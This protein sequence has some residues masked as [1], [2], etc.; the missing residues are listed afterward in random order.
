MYSHVSSP[1]GVCGPG[2]NAILGPTGSGK[3]SL[4]DILAAR[5]DPSGQTGDV[6]INGSPRPSNF[7]SMAGYVIQDDIVAGMLTVRENIAFSAAL[8]LPSSMP[9]KEKSARV[10]DV[11]N[12]LGLGKCAE[13]RVGTELIRGVSGGERKRTNIAMELI[14]SPQI[15]FL[16][17]PTT[18]LD[19]NTAYSVMHL[20]KRLSRRGKTVIFSVHQPRFSIY[21]LFDHVMLLS[22]GE[23]VYHGPAKEALGH[24]SDLGFV[25]E[26]HNNP[27]DFFLDVLNGGV[28][29]VSCP[30]KLHT[31]TVA[32]GDASA[33]ETNEMVDLVID[34]EEDE[35]AMSLRQKV[36]VER[37]KQSK[38]YLSLQEKLLPIEGHEAPST[39][40][41]NGTQY[42]TSFLRQLGVVGKR[43]W[44]NMIRNH[45]TMMTQLISAVILGL[46][47][48]SLYFQVDLSLTSGI[49]NRAGAFLFIVMNYIF[50]NMS[51]VDMFIK[52]RAIF[53]HENISGF[54][55]VSTYFFAKMLCDVMPQRFIPI[56]VFSLISYWMIGLQNDFMHFFFFCLNTILTCMA[57]TSVALLFSATMSTHTVGTILTAL[58]W[59]FMLVF[60]GLL[61]N[62]ETVPRFLRWGKHFSI[63]RYSMNGFLVNELKGLEFCGEIE[64]GNS[65]IRS[66]TTGDAY[67]K[68]QGIAHDSAWDLWLNPFGLAMLSLFF[69]S[70]TYVQLRRM[71]K[72]R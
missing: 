64:N 21:K 9:F 43:T 48:G 22:V 38:H 23:M 72:L 5:K 20:L 52:D 44:Q 62:I 19:A 57:G 53:I 37:Y 6:L 67:M 39:S 8:R 1:S 69:L 68:G 41:V 49:Q 35:D 28:L 27:P 15:L 18:G 59:V 32:N 4:M 65:S 36:L 7:K 3:T 30:A 42:A 24:F 14:T 26:E 16:D 17:E 47:I 55:R 51:A 33:T 50:G 13:T 70:V 60:N 11:I 63:F 40:V 56:T 34:I 61:V 10:E 12:E 46:L 71:K 29:P 25:C 58:V 54:Y 31:E 2:M 45:H 66:C